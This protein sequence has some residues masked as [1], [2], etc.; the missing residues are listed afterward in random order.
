MRFVSR[1]VLQKLSKDFSASHFVSATPRNI[2]ATW[3]GCSAALK[4]LRVTALSR[5]KN[6]PRF[7]FE[8]VKSQSRVARRSLRLARQLRRF[9]FFAIALA[10]NFL[11][12]LFRF[13]LPPLEGFRLPNCSFFVRAFCFLDFSFLAG[14]LAFEDDGG[15]DT[16]ITTTAMRFR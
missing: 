8:S 15:P 16:S 2:D 14:F 9:R 7:C 1:H 10:A 3:N 13:L 5:T 11:A 12:A 6:D 4:E